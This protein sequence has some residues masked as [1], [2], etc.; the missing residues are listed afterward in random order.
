MHK[1][2]YKI[3]PD[4]SIELTVSDDELKQAAQ[5]FFIPLVQREGITNAIDAITN[6]LDEAELNLAYTIFE[7]NVY[8]LNIL[9]RHERVI[10]IAERNAIK[11]Y[12]GG[13]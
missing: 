6:F 5:E 2:D 7:D 3:S 9:T 4:N 8:M 1:F 11:L 12:V 10:E 13:E